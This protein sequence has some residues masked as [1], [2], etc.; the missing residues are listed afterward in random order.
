MEVKAGCRGFTLVEIMVL[1]A[2]MGFL[3]IIALPHQS[4]AR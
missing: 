3:L 2:V 4:R 1:L